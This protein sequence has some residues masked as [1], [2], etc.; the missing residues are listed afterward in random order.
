MREKNLLKQR[1]LE[2]AAR[3]FVERGYNGIS[4][5]E[6]SEALKVSKAALYYHFK[7]KEALLLAILT[8]YLGEIE[9]LLDVN[10]PPVQDARTRLVHL[11]E[12]IFNQPLERRA[13]I[14]LASQE[15]P[16]LRSEARQSFHALYH[17]KF[18]GKIE[19]ILQDGIERAEFKPINVQAAAW[20][21][22]GMMYPF[23]YA[24]PERDLQP[25]DPLIYMMTEIFLNG[26]AQ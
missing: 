14:R 9:T 4:M 5:R 26:I 21:L 24:S 19:A 20:I 13:I 12:T 18:I 15:I 11:V 3:L 22:L 16:S 6:I 25:G 8:G 10:C 2:E 1:I 7:D 17:Q 23:F